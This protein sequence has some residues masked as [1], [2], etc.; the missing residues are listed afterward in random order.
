M[1]LRSI[2]DVFKGDFSMAKSAIVQRLEKTKENVD[3]RDNGFTQHWPRLRE[4]ADLMVLSFGAPGSTEREL[5]AGFIDDVWPSGTDV[6]TV[7]VYVDRF[8]WIGNHDLAMVPDAQFYGNGGGGGS[9]VKVKNQHFKGPGKSVP[10]RT[11]NIG[12]DVPEGAMER[13]LVW[14]RKNHRSFA[15]P[16]RQHWEGRCSVMDDEC[17][18]LLIASHI[19]PWA[20]STPQEKTDFNN[21]LLL[22]APLDRLFDRGL[23]SFSNTGEMLI[24]AHLSKKTR[25]VFGIPKRSYSITRREKI[26]SKMKGYLKRHR[27]RYGFE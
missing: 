18:G 12:A 13:R 7:R 17:D 24:K 10:S 4:P 23:I 8:H 14:V 27:L 26:T 1:L 19:Y 21:G 16:V 15:D 5:W 20:K 11:L 9:R 2:Q 22:S 3:A 6:S 25:E